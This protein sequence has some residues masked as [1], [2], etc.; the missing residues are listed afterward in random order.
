MNHLDRNYDPL[1]PNPI[2]VHVNTE[3]YLSESTVQEI[4]LFSSSIIKLSIRLLKMYFFLKFKF[5]NLFLG[6]QVVIT[7]LKYYLTN[8]LEKVHF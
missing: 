5:F 1:N 4:K 2:C 6:H 7:S 3:D 8:F